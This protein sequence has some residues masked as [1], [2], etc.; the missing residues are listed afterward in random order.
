MR[1][2]LAFERALVDALDA[3]PTSVPPGLVD[4]ALDLASKVRQRRPRFR[5]LDA[6]AW[7]RGSGPD[8]I[9]A[10]RLLLRIAIVGLLMAALL[11]GAAAGGLL[12][13][14]APWLHLP[15]PLVEELGTFTDGQVSAFSAAVLADGRVLLAG[16]VD[17]RNGQTTLASAWIFDPDSG[18]ITP[19]G[20]MVSPR[21]DPL[22][23]ALADG[24]VLV[25]G[26]WVD[27]A[28]TQSQ[29]P[30]PGAELYDPATGTFRALAAGPQ[31][32]SE[33]ACGALAG[34]PWAI[35]HASVLGDGRV[36]VTGGYIDDQGR[37]SVA[38]VF[39]PRSGQWAALDVG[40]DAMR[41]TQTIL[42]DGRALVLCV[43]RDGVRARLFNPTTNAFAEAAAPPSAA[44]AAILLD[45]GRVLLTGFDPMLYDPAAD[46]FTTVPLQV[47]LANQRGVSIGSDR[48]LYM[49]F[50]GLPTEVSPTYLFDAR[51][52][53]L[54]LLQQQGFAAL[55]EVVRLPDG[56]ILTVGYQLKARLIDPSQLP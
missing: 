21:A 39:D 26:G 18:R 38:E 27:D 32:R 4:G 6:R 19:T 28:P 5:A 23:A 56:R 10:R 29:E 8:A 33:C 12:R 50:D 20:S 25:F 36:L 16:G 17:T 46:A 45:D 22:L 51:T 35:V 54:T 14:V 42:A 3:G 40:C 44:R 48:V 37:N 9:E 11:T 55:D 47:A 7:P 43:T 13:R 53:H 49:G 15:F 24:R 2:N 30:A 31:R 52:F 41:G 34:L 1:E